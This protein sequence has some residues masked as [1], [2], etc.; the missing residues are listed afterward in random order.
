MPRHLPTT[1]L[2]PAPQP[3]VASRTEWQA[4]LD[5]LLTREKAHTRESDAIAALRRRLPMTPVAP[6]ATVVG[7]AG[8]VPFVE[9]FD[10]RRMLAGYFHMWHDGKAWEGQCEGCTVIASHIQT[11]LAY[12]HQRDVTLA[13]FCEGTYAESAP[14]AEFLG[15]RT[16]WWSARESSVV[17]GRGFGFFA[18]FL[19]DDDDNVFE[20]YWTTGR[21]T[22]LALWSYALLDRTAYGRQEAWQDSPPG[23]PTLDVSDGSITDVG[24]QQWRVDG[25]PTVQWQ[26]TDAPA[27][28]D[29]R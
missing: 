1:P 3:S 20:T 4:E 21:G 5:R 2:A 15:Y 27:G 28:S 9:A 13:I 17:A 19:R 12:L 8:E 7:A 29:G 26:V 24:G 11:P 6:D 16:P 10:G 25:R 23:W 14:Y 18:F 22:E